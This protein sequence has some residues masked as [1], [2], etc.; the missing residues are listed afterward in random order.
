VHTRILIAA[1][2]GHYLVFR[3]STGR[4]VAVT[5]TFQDEQKADSLFPASESFVRYSDARGRSYGVTR[6]LTLILESE[7]RNFHPWL[8]SD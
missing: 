2:A 7:L 3:R 8:S 4:L 6:Q 5:R 1:A